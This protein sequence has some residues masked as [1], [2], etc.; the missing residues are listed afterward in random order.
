MAKPMWSVLNEAVEERVG[1]SEFLVQ[2]TKLQSPEFGNE[3]L[4]NLL[5]GSLQE[6]VSIDV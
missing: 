2:I 6:V 1:S 3:A 4:L 5:N